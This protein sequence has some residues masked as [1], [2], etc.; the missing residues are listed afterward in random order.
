[1]CLLCVEVQGCVKEE[2]CR[3]VPRWQLWQPLRQSDVGLSTIRLVC[4]L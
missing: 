1:M 3:I 4:W 2:G